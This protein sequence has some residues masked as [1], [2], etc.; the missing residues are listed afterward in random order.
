MFC[1]VRIS[2]RVVREHY[3]LHRFAK[4]VETLKDPSYIHAMGM[5]DRRAAVE[6]DEL[7]RERRRLERAVETNAEKK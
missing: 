7:R 1:A 5:D 6:L 2:C 3:V 4:Y